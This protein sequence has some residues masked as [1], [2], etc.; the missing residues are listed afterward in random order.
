MLLPEK[1]MRDGDKN[2]EVE[3]IICEFFVELLLKAGKCRAGFENALCGLLRF[4]IDGDR[5]IG[6]NGAATD[7]FKLAGEGGFRVEQCL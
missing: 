5:S 4:Q 6:L 1:A 3:G 7:N 2:A